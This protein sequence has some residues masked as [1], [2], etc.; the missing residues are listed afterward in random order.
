MALDEPNDE[1]E[2][3]AENDQ[4]QALEA[5]L[6]RKRADLEAEVERMA[7]AAEALVVDGPVVG[8]PPQGPSIGPPAPEPVVAPAVH[9]LVVEHERPAPVGIRRKT[10][11]RTPAAG[12]SEQ[13][14]RR[15]LV[16]RV[17]R[18]LLILWIAV[19]AVALIGSGAWAAMRGDWEDVFY[20]ACAFLMF[21][22]VFDE[23]RRRKIAKRMTAASAEAT[24]T[25]AEEEPSPMGWFPPKSPLGWVAVPLAALLIFVGVPDEG[26]EKADEYNRLS[27][28]VTALREKTAAAEGEL[29]RMFEGDVLEPLISWP[30]GEVELGDPSAEEAAALLPVLKQARVL[31]AEKHEDHA[32][33]AALWDQMA[34]LDTD[35]ADTAYCGQQRRLEELGAQMSVLLVQCFAKLE[36]SCT[37]AP[38]SQAEADVLEEEISDLLAR[39]DQLRQRFAELLR[40]S[41]QYYDEKL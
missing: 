4:I 41:Q 34:R 17:L 33:T 9:G 15:S 12:R 7:A 1:T 14:G 35:A 39:H 36:E 40:A 3:A 10:K 31:A 28:Q 8:P 27:A 23:D 20:V 22:W 21:A 26:S 32:S 29:D 25:P 38:L 2:S 18:V 5:E 16:R 37:R 30:A 13:A 6:E 19:F 24:K 11:T